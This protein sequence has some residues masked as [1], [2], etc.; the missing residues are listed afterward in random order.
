MNRSPYDVLGVPM[1]ATD[2]EIKAAYRKLAK[3]YHPDL[4]GGSAAAETRMKEINEAYN[5]LIKH[6][7]EAQP[8]A[9]AYGQSQPYWGGAGQQYTYQNTG[10][11]YAFDFGEFFRRMQQNQQTAGDEG[12]SSTYVEMDPRLKRAED[13]YRDRDFTRM[14]QVLSEIPS[15]TAGWYYWSA[16][17]DLATGSRV[18][19]LNNARMAAQLNP[20]EAAFT[21]LYQQLQSR[22]QTYRRAGTMQGFLGGLCSNPCLT[23]LAANAVCSCCFRGFCC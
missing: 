12:Y 7:G 13:A 23:C 1:T 5:L 15:R 17:L 10:G 2:D 6:K 4:N 3:Q 19:A 9:G 18:S 14:R 8:G 16:A 21:S 11:G 22:G 20:S